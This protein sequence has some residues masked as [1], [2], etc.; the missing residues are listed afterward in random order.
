MDLEIDH[1]VA[2]NV[3]HGLPLAAGRQYA[4]RLVI[5]GKTDDDWVVPFL[6]RA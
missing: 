4:W 5:D 3:A 1:N 6:V 2:I